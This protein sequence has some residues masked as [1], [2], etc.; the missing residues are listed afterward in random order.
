MSGTGAKFERFLSNI[1]LTKT[2]LDDAVTKHTG[3]RKTLHTAYY[4]EPYDGTT[5]ILVGSYGKNS[6]VRPPA[7]IDILFKMPSSLFKK[8][9]A[10]SGNGQSQLLQDVKSTLKKTY[11]TT[12]MRA[13][14]QVVGVPFSTFAVEV[15]PVFARSGGG[16]LTPDTHGGGSW[17]VT[18]P[19][20]EMNRL[21]GSNSRSNGKT[22][23]LLKMMKVWKSACK[24]P[25]KSFAIELMVV[26]FLATWRYWDKTSVYYDWMVRDFLAHMLQRVNGSAVIPGTS[27]SLPF[28]D[29]WQTRAESALDRAKNACA[30]EGD[31]QN[32]ELATAEWKKIF[33]DLFPG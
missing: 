33:G 1:Q 29:E 22:I 4:S 17:K 32:D 21:T 18:D 5:S 31:Q 9:D 30:H 12:D 28:G 7:D 6:A 27:G 8:Y 20:A 25:I 16:Y 10:S 13:D 11:P 3:V 15:V 2:Q 23:H 19:S 24:V 26:D 14:G